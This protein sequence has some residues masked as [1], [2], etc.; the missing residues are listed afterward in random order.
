LIQH[1]QM[2]LGQMMFDLHSWFL[3]SEMMQQLKLV[4]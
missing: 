2:F 3:E 4:H 1:S